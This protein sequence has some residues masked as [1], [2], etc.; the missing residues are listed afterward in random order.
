LRGGDIAPTDVLASMAKLV[1][2]SLVSL[3]AEMGGSFYRPLETTRGYAL[4]KLEESS[5]RTTWRGAEVG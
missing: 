4:V 1:A 3:G 5:E 2:G